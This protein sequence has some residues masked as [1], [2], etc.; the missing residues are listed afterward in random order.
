MYL[1][2]ACSASGCSRC[3]H[4]LEFYFQRWSFQCSPR[5]GRVAGAHELNDADRLP[6]SEVLAIAILVELGLELAHD[7]HP[8]QYKGD[9]DDHSRATLRLGVAIGDPGEGVDCV[10]VTLRFLVRQKLGACNDET[11]AEKQVR[12]LH[13]A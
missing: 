4:S 12:I 8:V 3:M 13:T 1:L 6:P 11:T 10:S 2:T 5:G 7:V 9:G